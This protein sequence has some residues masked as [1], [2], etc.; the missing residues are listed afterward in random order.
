MSR[1]NAANSGD[2]LVE[3]LIG[4]G[5][6]IARYLHV[7]CACLIVGGTLFYEMVVPVAIADLKNEQQLAIFAR[8]R[9]VFRQIVWGSAIVLALSGVVTTGQQW[10]AYMQAEERVVAITPTGTVQS[11]PPAAILRRPDWWWVAHVSTGLMALLISVSLTLGSSPP[12]HPI[13]WMRLNLIVLLIVIFLGSITRHMRQ[14]FIEQKLKFEE[15]PSIGF[16]FPE[17]TTEPAT[18]PASQP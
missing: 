4:I 18:Q 15:H 9:W 2:S 11:S 6:L 12:M 10:H 3:L 7:V 17:P 13:R 5:Y 1:H 8:A 14:D 16:G